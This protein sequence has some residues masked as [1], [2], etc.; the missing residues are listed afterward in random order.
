[1][2]SQRNKVTGERDFPGLVMEDVLRWHNNW[3]ANHPE[4]KLW[5]EGVL[6]YARR[7]RE[8]RVPFGDE[9]AR[10]W[11]GGVDKANATFNHHIQGGAGAVMN[12]ATIALA[13]AI[14]FRSWSGMTGLAIQVHDYLGGFVPK[15]RAEEAKGLFRECMETMFMDRVKLTCTPEVSFRWSDQ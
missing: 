12:Q 14:P 1:M 11:P 4:T 5:Q 8:S 3:H 10:F 9:R 2:A 15:D 7:K 6:R 13:Q